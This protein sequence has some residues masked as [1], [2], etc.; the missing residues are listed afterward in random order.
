MPGAEPEVPSDKGLYRPAQPQAVVPQQPAAPPVKTAVPPETAGEVKPFELPAEKMDILDEDLQDI[1]RGMNKH[2]EQQVAEI[3]SSLTRRQE[4]SELQSQHNEE[5]QFDKCV[6]ALGSDW[7]DVFGEG[8]RVE[9]FQAGQ[10]DPVAMTNFNHRKLLFNAVQAVREV[11]AK[12][13]YKP[14]SLDQEVQWALMQR[15]PDKFQQ[16]ISGNGKR[17]QRQG[18]TASRPTQRRTPPKNQ[19]SKL[20]ADVNTMLKKKHGHSLDMGH[21]EEVDGEI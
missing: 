4:D 3:R 20:L 18:A 15:Y 12:Q 9:L 7:Q 1:L 2:Y 10:R 6:N 5:V 16:T 19:D 14:M 8:G 21:D 13:G 11:N 17:A